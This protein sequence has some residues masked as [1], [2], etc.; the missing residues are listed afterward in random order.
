MTDQTHLSKC[1]REFFSEFMIEKLD[2]INETTLKQV[3]FDEQSLKITQTTDGGNSILEHKTDVEN[4]LQ[5]VH[6]YMPNSSSANA[7]V[8]TR[9]TAQSCVNAPSSGNAAATSQKAIKSTAKSQ[10][11]NGQES[12]NQK[13][14]LSTK[15]C[16]NERNSSLSKKHTVVDK[17]TSISTT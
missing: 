5:D 10:K 17:E 6:G 3:Q 14:T 9:A 7:A 1:V 11:V 15:N 13:E 16:R 8:T 4:F 12:E 2:G